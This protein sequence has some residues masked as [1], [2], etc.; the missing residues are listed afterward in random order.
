MSDIIDIMGKPLG[1]TDISQAITELEQD[2]TM[3]LTKYNGRLPP[4]VAVGVLHWMAQNIF[5]IATMNAAMQNMAMQ[6][7]MQEAAGKIPIQ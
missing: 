2:L 4:S 3:V 7:R 6:Q 1:P 5:H